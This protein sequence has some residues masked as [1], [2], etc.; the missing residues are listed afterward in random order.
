MEPRLSII[1]PWLDRPQFIGDYERATAE[2]GVE[3]IVIDNG[4]AR[5]NA[6]ALRAMIDRLGGVYIRNER[7]RWFSGANNQGLARARGP[8]VLFLNNDIWAERGWTSSV[9]ADVAGHALY[10]PALARTQVQGT[11][12]EYVEGWCIAGSRELWERLGG[13]DDKAYAMPYFEDL[14]LSLRA[15]A[16]GIELKQANWPVFHKK[17]GT[18]VDVPGVPLAFERNRKTFE[19][20]LH[21]NAGALST[22]IDESPTLQS[23]AALLR[24]K[25]IAEAE[26]VLAA[27]VQKEPQ[28][29]GAWMHY[30]QAL[31]LS[32][33]GEAAVDAMNRAVQLSPRAH[34]SFNGLGVL[35]ARLGRQAEAVEAF[36]RAIN[37]SPDA[38]DVHN[39][40]ARSLA[41]LGRFE[42]SAQAASRAVTLAPHSAAAHINLS[43]ALRELKEFPESLEAA[44]RACMLDPSSALAIANLAQSLYAAS[45]RSEAIAA[46]QEALRRTPDNATFQRLYLS[47]TNLPNSENKES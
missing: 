9:M 5:D 20:K 18:C 11:Q 30:S 14:D 7:N 21:G 40:L 8:I 29:V 37:L 34:Q 3:V 2:P 6:S 42:E 32:G 38:A 26:A 46:I 10:G 17:N 16:M 44:H 27:V 31:Y 47:M 36:G 19:A 35:L 24:E 28:N 41:Q 45:H 39:N 43:T 23:A 22:S 13:W 12:I 33:R 4:S 25:R 1:T 15:K